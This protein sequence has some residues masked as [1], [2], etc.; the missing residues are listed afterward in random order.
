M[1]MLRPLRLA[2]VFLAATCLSLASGCDDG[3][4]G[5]DGDAT[6]STSTTTTDAGDD[7]TSATDTATDTASTDVPTDPATMAECTD[8]VTDDYVVEFLDLASADETVKIRLARYVGEGTAVGETFPLAL[9]AFALERDGVLTCV[10]DPGALG[11]EYGHHNWAEVVDVDL[12]DG[13]SVHYTM[14]VEFTDT[15]LIW[16]DVIELTGTAPLGPLDL[17]ATACATV[18]AGDP[19]FCFR[20][21][22]TD[23]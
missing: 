14:T 17:E 8:W 9:G 13:T 18:P 12:G 10:T 15:D 20:R 23:Q 1:A 4:S 6:T 11:Y 16:N 21:P 22:R 5:N 7:A 2:L 3:G 19:N